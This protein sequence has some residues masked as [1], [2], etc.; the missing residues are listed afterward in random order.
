MIAMHKDANPAA[1]FA[2]D[3]VHRSFTKLHKIGF[4]RAVLESIAEFPVNTP[5]G[6]YLGYATTYEVDLQ[7]LCKVIQRTTRGLHFYEFKAPLPD[8]HRCVT[9]ALEGFKSAS[10][11]IKARMQLFL[12]CALSGKKR[13]FGNDAFV[14]WVRRLDDANP[15]TLWAFVV[16]GCVEFVALTMPNPSIRISDGAC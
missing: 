1:A 5:A 9:Y 15:A 12:D 7:R 14:Y 13:T 4:T 16:Y 11:E 8:D 2:R 10:S 3:A 6:L